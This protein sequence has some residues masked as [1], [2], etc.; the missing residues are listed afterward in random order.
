MPFVYESK[1][2]VYHFKRLRTIEKLIICS[3]WQYPDLVK[4]LFWTWAFKPKLKPK[5][6]P[7]FKKD[8]HYVHQLKDV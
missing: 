4:A 7:T 2:L 3:Y 1:I 5:L 6:I 8:K